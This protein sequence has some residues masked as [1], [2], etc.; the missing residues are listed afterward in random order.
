MARNLGLCFDGTN[1]QYTADNT[2]VV[3][4]YAMLDRS[5]TDQLSYYQPGIGTMSPPGMY[6]KIKQWLITKVDLALAILLDN[7][8]KDG[9][10]FL[11]RYYQPGDRIF[12]F[13]F[14]RGAYT[15]RVMAGMIHKVGLL[16]AGNEELIHHAPVR[17]CCRSG[18]LGCIRMSGAATWNPKQAC[19]KLH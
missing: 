1:N 18:F 7:H 6:G 10:R 2:N 14:S 12:I 19:P 8:V 15:A 4:I 13:G 9:Y 5:R 16:S 3:K 11:M 17:T